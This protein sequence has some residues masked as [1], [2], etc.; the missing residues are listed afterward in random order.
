LPI[1]DQWAPGDLNPE[2]AL[3]ES[4]ALTD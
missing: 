1:F 2:P 4:D 3:Y